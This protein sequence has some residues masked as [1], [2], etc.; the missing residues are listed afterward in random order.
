MVPGSAISF[1][2]IW[3]SLMP[4]ARKPPSAVRTST[5]ASEIP[6]GRAQ[7]TRPSGPNR[8]TV[9]FPVSTAVH[10]LDDDSFSA[11]VRCH[12]PGGEIYQIAITR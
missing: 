4:P 9:P 7:S 12:D 8:T 11:V 10:A 6:E 1:D 5:C 2:E 3:E